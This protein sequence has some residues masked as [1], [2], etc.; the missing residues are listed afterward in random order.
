MYAYIVENPGYLVFT[1]E[2]ALDFLNR[3]TTNDVLNFQKDMAL[4]TVL[5]NPTARVLDVLTLLPEKMSDNDRYKNHQGVHVITLPGYAVSTKDFLKS[6]IFFMD[7]V[8]VDDR[9]E[10]FTQ[11]ELFGRESGL[12]L[13]EIVS[14]KLPRPGEVIHCELQKGWFRLIGVIKGL[15]LGYKLIIDDTVKTELLRKLESSDIEFVD[16]NRY[17]LSRIEAG[18]PGAGFELTAEYTPL[19]VGLE[20]LVS[21]TKGCYTGQEVIARQINFDKV[22]KRLCGI[23]AQQTISVGD[24][25]WIKGKSVGE[26]TSTGYSDRSGIIALAVIKRPHTEIGSQLEVGEEY[27]ETIQTVVTKLP[28][29]I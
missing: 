13:K 27:R 4:A 22:T 10:T 25:V 28:F 24:R 8:E 20:Q 11:V 9:S 1:G 14:G 7:K 23:S 12:G 5:T 17:E 2:D 18:I 3:Q 21:V 29:S 6:R 15:Q 16:K 19:E 26:I